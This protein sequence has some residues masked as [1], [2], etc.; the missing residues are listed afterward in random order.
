MHTFLLKDINFA[1]QNDFLKHKDFILD[2]FQVCV[3]DYNKTGGSF[4]DKYF[5]KEDSNR[6]FKYY[7]FHLDITY[8]RYRSE[9]LFKN[10]L[11]KV[12]NSINSITA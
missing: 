2:T 8:P 4:N 1:I 11:E 6:L 9:I 10:I 5:L 3:N 7:G 12:S